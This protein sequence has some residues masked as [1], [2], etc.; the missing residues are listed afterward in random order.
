MPDPVF[1]AAVAFVLR[2]EGGLSDNPA[3]PGGL[4]NFGI[5]L[6]AYPQLGSEGIRGLT[7]EKAAAIYFTDWW[8]PLRFGQLPTPFA[9]KAFDAAVNMGERAVELLQQAVNACDPA[10]PIAIDGGI[11]PIT[12][13]ASRAVNPSAL[14]TR[15]TQNL[16][17][18]YRQLVENNPAMG[19]FLDGW[20]ARAEDWEI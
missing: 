6:R 2:H 15:Y 18:H 12:A 1:Q 16:A 5:S 11:G 17:G 4:T 9:A 14:R 10:H 20:L 19:V 7:A 13:A 3:D 8:L